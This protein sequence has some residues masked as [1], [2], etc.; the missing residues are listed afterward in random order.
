VP[1]SLSTVDFCFREKNKSRRLLD[2]T[3]LLRKSEMAALFAWK[4]MEKTMEKLLLAK[5]LMCYN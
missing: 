4:T 1:S 5:E 3:K 2:F